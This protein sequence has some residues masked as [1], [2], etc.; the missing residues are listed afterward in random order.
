MLKKIFSTKRK[1]DPGRHNTSKIT[2]DPA[3]AAI[4]TRHFSPLSC[5]AK[6]PSDLLDIVGYPT[7]ALFSP[8]LYPTPFQHE[9]NQ[10]QRLTIRNNT[11]PNHDTL[12]LETSRED[13]TLVEEQV[14]EVVEDLTTLEVI[15]L[16]QKLI[17]FEQ[18]RE[19]WQEKLQGYIE[20]EEHMRKIIQENQEQLN[21]LQDKFNSTPKRHDSYRTVSTLSTSWPTEPD[22]QDLY[23]YSCYPNKPVY[24][25]YYYQPYYYYD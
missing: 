12:L 15:R 24:Y 13:K 22:E 10:R 8:V 11:T 5:R 9:E 18:E 3:S 6:S 1:Q 23:Y 4:L 19:L 14:Q 7:T 17:E 21:Q 2:M 20:R 16:H 25:N